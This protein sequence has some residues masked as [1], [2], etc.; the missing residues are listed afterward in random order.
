VKEALSDWFLGELADWQ[1]EIDLGDD[2]VMT[3]TPDS[4]CSDTIGAH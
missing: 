3:I 2:L 4:L 1:Q